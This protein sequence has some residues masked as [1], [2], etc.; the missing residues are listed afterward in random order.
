MPTIAFVIDHGPV[1]ASAVH[2][3]PGVTDTPMSTNDPAALLAKVPDN[4]DTIG[5]YKLRE[6]LGWGEARYEVARDALVTAGTLAKGQGRGGTVRRLAAQSA[7]QPAVAAKTAKA[8]SEKVK[9]CFH[10][11]E[12]AEDD[13]SIKYHGYLSIFLNWATKTTSSYIV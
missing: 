2:G 4:G 1:V 12:H 8:N 10:Q 9:A 3:T 5:N 6:A 13:E 11:C 7:A